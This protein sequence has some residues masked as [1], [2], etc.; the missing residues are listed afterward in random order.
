MAATNRDEGLNWKAI[1]AAMLYFTSFFAVCYALYG[2]TNEAPFFDSL[3]FAFP[4]VLAACV[5][6]F[7]CCVVLEAYRA[8]L[9]RSADKVRTAP[10][11]LALP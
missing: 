5:L 8:S 1:V 9:K 11:R 7:A 4:R 6:M 2:L 3:V 10:K